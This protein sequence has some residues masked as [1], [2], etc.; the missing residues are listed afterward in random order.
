MHRNTIPFK[1]AAGYCAVAVVLL[2]A[3]GLVYSNTKSILAVNHASREYI[4]KREAADS[5]MSSLLKAEQANLQQLSEAMKERTGKNYLHEKVESLDKGEDSV[6]VHPKTPQKVQ[7]KSTVVEVVKTRKGFFRRVA[8][9]FRKER[10]D[11]VSIKVDND[12]AVIDTVVTP[13]NVASNVV[14]ILK[15]VDRKERVTT[16]HQ[17]KAVH[18]EMADLKVINAQ[19]ALKS[20]QQLREV[21]RRE[22]KSIQQSI[23]QAM[24]AQRHLLWQMGMLAVVAVVAAVILIGYVWRDSRRERIYQETLERANEEIQRIMR[25]RER[26]LLTITHDI[27]APAASISGFIDMMRDY[28]DQPRGRECLD[29][30]QG[31]ARHLSHL[32][33]SLLDYHQLENGLMEVHPVNFSPSQL[34]RECVEGHR[35]KAEEKGLQMALTWMDKTA[36]ETEQGRKN[37]I[38]RADAFRLR[39]ILDNLVGN[40]VKYTE[41]GSV[42][43]VAALS[44]DDNK[45]EKE[46]RLTVAVK[47]TGRGMTTQEKHD[48]FQAFTRL[49]N[50]QGV[51]GA[52]LGLS[53][54]HELA[55]LLGGDIQVKSAVGRGSTFTVT[56]P[57]EEGTEKTEA[58]KVAEAPATL[59]SVEWRD[60]KILLLDDDPLQLQLLQEMLRRLPIDPEKVIV[61]HHV[62]DALTA[63]HNEKPSLML[64]DIEMPEMNGME[65]IQHL[66]HSHMRVV[67]MTAHDSSILDQLKE[68]GFDDCLFKPFR[69]DALA[70]ILGI[71]QDHVASMA[72]TPS[73]P[74]SIPP[75]FA[76][77]VAFADDDPEA[78]EE[79][80]RTVRQELKQYLTL[81][82]QIQNP[83][84]N[85]DDSAKSTDEVSPTVSIGKIAHKL[86]PIA[87]MMQMDCL[88]A[89]TSLSPE[90]IEGLAQ[91]QIQQCLQIVI[92]ELQDIL[93]EN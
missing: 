18:K 58:E 45:E 22:R 5:V 82:R 64:M 19:L 29:H 78:A 41:Q 93:E 17:A 49:K 39:Q 36:G 71:S 57:L 81:L 62:T 89:L 23:N 53:I 42:S 14:T 38:C 24:A 46:F 11:T 13:V 40:A 69:V 67:A 85:P 74:T 32:V 31:S 77:L 79:I 68:A 1:V 34:L 12:T 91:P 86:L 37:T 30:I 48:V 75:R 54:T 10:A 9:V 25:Q 63:L 35:L 4:R 8:D 84:S 83:S 2:L 56:I 60:Q 51:E 44:T 70:K 16:G 15:Q 73:Q 72:P 47:D 50:A 52:G 28:V 3:I 20:T 80:I 90:R 76:P 43:V 7:E 92:H 66:N 33:A 87:T 26:L 21:H 55:T 65:I 59:P 6:V 88:E 27:K 61:C